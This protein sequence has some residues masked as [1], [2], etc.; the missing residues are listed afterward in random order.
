MFDKQTA[1]V[2]KFF[3]ETFQA[4]KLE[5]DPAKYL[6]KFRAEIKATGRVFQYLE[7]A[8]PDKK[9]PFGWKPAPRLL[10]LIAKVNGPSNQTTKSASNMEP[11]VLDLM[12]DTVLGNDYSQSEGCFCCH[13]LIKLGLVYEDSIGDWIPTVALANLF[14]H[15]YYTRAFRKLAQDR[16]AVYEVVYTG[17]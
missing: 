6:D 9:S 14:V 2:I 4:G 13:V 12:L 7:L 17:K 11:F 1:L 16:D 10:D 8:E 3:Q 5:P 15:T